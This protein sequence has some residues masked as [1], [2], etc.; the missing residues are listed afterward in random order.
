MTPLRRISGVKGKGRVCKT[1]GR[2]R[3][4]HLRITSRIQVCMLEFTVAIAGG[5]R[6][7]HAPGLQRTKRNKAAW[8]HA[9][10]L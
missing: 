3:S 5:E 4:E 7:E 6:K 8:I 1:C 2:F 10:R 9:S